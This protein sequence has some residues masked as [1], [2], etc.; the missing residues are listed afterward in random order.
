MLKKGDKIYAKKG[1]TI[2]ALVQYCMP[3]TGGVTL[4]IPEN[5]AFSVDDDA[6]K[7][8]INPNNMIVNITADDYSLFQLLIPEKVKNSE[9]YMAVYISLTTDKVI[10]KF[11]ISH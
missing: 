11:L 7:S 5:M 6:A 3:F 8:M 1:C 4:N 2:E 9:N 10:E